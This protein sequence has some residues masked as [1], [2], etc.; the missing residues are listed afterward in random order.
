MP[1]STAEEKLLKGARTNDVYMIK[2][3]L[4]EGARIHAGDEDGNTALHLALLD[5]GQN[6][7]ELLLRHRASQGEAVLACLS[8]QH[9]R[10]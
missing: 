7:I 9:P 2:E 8:R 5:G 6:S 1:L 3:A 4:S 10:V